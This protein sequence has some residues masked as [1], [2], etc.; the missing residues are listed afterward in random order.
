MPSFFPTRAARRYEVAGTALM[1]GNPCCLPARFRSADP[2][3]CGI[4]GEQAAAQDPGSGHSEPD[5]MVQ[6]QIF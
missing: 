6:L 2:L 3:M 5:A 4:P 1:L